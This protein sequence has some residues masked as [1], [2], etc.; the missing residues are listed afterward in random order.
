M[1]VRIET[2]KQI[3]FFSAAAAGSAAIVLAGTKIIDKH[4]KKW[5]N[6]GLSVG[7]RLCD[8]YDELLEDS[9]SLCRE[10]NRDFEE[11]KKKGSFDESPEPV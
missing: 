8:D 7:L 4:R 5:F 3:G 9:I 11:L 2:M 10:F 6:K 1:K